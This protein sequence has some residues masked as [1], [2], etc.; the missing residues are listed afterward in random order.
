[1]SSLSVI[2][3]PRPPV[4][5]VWAPPRSLMA[6]AV[7]AADEAAWSYEPVGATAGD[8]PDGYLHDVRSAVIGEGDHAFQRG[9]AALRRW[10]QFDLPWVRLFRSDIPIRPGEI[11][12]FSSRQLG[13]WALNVC[14]IVYVI[15]EPHRF[16]FA[17]GTLK[18]HA[19]A[20]EERFL[21]EFDPESSAVRFEIKKYSRLQNPL[22]R[23]AGPAARAV[24]ARFSREALEALRRAV[25]A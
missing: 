12:A 13:L 10:A 7:R 9:R 11:V 4:L 15:D 17:Y 1:M 20:G 19:V 22:V 8:M 3:P 16:G 25:Q 24:Q 14:R 6:T 23:I 21:L 5:H 18:G 2:V